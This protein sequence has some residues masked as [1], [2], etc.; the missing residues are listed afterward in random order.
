MKDKTYVP[1]LGEK[2]EIK[3]DFNKKVNKGITSICAKSIK[4]IDDTIS[5]ND[6]VQIFFQ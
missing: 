1:L 6:L 2:E 5:N 4:I 3:K